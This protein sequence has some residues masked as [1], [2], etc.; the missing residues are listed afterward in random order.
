MRHKKWGKEAHGQH[1]PSTTTLTLSTR[2]MSKANVMHQSQCHTHS[3]TLCTR[4][5]PFQPA[6]LSGQSHNC[7]ATPPWA[8]R[9][10]PSRP[11]VFPWSWCPRPPSAQYNPWKDPSQSRPKYQSTGHRALFTADRGRMM[12]SLRAGEMTWLVRTTVL[13]M[14]MVI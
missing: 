7:G 8:W 5:P 12:M 4:R 9:P 10:P 11:V 3:R 1:R 14:L 13:P 6:C 2:R